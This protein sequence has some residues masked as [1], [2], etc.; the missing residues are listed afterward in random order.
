MK[1]LAVSTNKGGVLKTSI[2]VN[3]AG[4]LFK[5]KRVLIIDGDNQGNVALSFGHNPDSFT[6]TLY[7]ALIDG[8]DPREAIVNVHHN[9]DLL[10]SNDDLI[11]LEFDVLPSRD[12]FGNPFLLLKELVDK[13]RGMYDVILI[14]TPPNLGL[15]QGNVLACADQVLIPFQ[16]ENYS[17]R[18]LVKIL[19][20]IGDFRKNF[21]PMLSVLGIVA[22]L[23]DQRTTLHST[24]I[25]E[26]RQFSLEQR[27]RMFD[28]I[29]PKSIRFAS[30]VAFDRLPATLAHPNHPVVAYYAELLKEVEEL[31][32]KW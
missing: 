13:L 8:A 20:A 10:P 26:C 32:E 27:V 17:M 31:E 1:V 30:S 12:K 29:I 3:L 23:V 15:M 5:N 16:P 2:T 28:T 6:T 14:D 9:I 25:Q 19:K 21:N 18:S 4:L 11:F 24:V 7:D 22:T